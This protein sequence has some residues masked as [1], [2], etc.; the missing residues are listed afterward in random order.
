MVYIT[1]RVRQIFQLLPR[2]LQAFQSSSQSGSESP[3]HRRPWVGSPRRGP[4]G[5][6]PSRRAARSWV[7]REDL[8]LNKLFGHELHVVI[9]S[10]Q[11]LIVLV[12]EKLL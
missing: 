3:W 11:T 8:N 1:L 4:C 10:N 6:S 5:R 9:I 7:D 12:N 2:M